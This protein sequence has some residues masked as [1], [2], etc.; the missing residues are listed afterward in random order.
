MEVLVADWIL[1]LLSLTGYVVGVLLSKISPE[2]MKPGKRYFLVI[3]KIIFWIII[4]VPFFEGLSWTYPGLL[5]I[6]VLILLLFRMLGKGI[7]KVVLNYVLFISSYLV[8]LN[9][10]R[11][12]YLALVF[13]YGL[14]VRKPG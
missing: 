1:I 10:M 6:Y 12:I 11:F 14:P 2:E 7:N 4:I 9:S 8:C 3:R 5:A 13:L